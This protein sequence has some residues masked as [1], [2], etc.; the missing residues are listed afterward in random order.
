MTKSINYNR[1]TKVLIFIVAYNAEK[2]IEKV[3]TRIP[4]SLATDYIT[5]VLIIDDHSQDDTV[6]RCET[7][8]KNGLLKFET[9]VLVNPKNQGYGGNQKIGFHYAIEHDY[10][11]IVLLHGD[12]QY[13][14][15]CLPTLLQTISEKKA[16]AVFGSRMLKR[17]GALREGMP[18]YKY[19]GNKVLSFV[20][21]RILK[22]SLSE[23]HSGYRVYSVATLKQIPFHLNTDDFHFDTEIIIQLLFAG[24]RIK[25]CPIPTFYGGEICYVK[26]LKY[27]KDVV[28][29]TF[30]ARAQHLGVFYE[31]K[32]DC[33]PHR[34]ENSHYAS[35][36]NFDSPS[37]RAFEEIPPYSNILDI[38]CG[39]GLL[40]ERLASRGCTG[41]GVDKFPPQE[42]GNRFAFYTCDINTE[43][44]PVNVADYDYILMLDILE[45]FLKPE[46][47]IEKMNYACRFSPKLKIIASTGNI[48]FFL[49]RLMLLAGQFNYGKRGILDLTHTR[50]FTFK[51]FRKLFE[52]A[53]FDVIWFKGIPA[54]FVLAF[55]DNSGSRFLMW[56]NQLLIWL[57]PSLFSYQIYLIAKPKR[58]LELLLKD[59]KTEG[60]RRV[61][62]TQGRAF[63][64]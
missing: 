26:G 55:G 34:S 46:E 49:I 8:I 36:L 25:E 57:C 24:H 27:A 52:Q 41:A 1:K 54:P 30:K 45:H 53:G 37:L 56:L 47:F 17:F 64:G 20:Q 9:H 48:A 16:D 32:F 42:T 7:A 38:G 5:E 62:E 61:N 58:S 60:Y 23:F 50:L 6:A 22:S 15:E 21:N 40:L 19:I 14:P 44:L 10:D 35:K 31:R 12:G 63:E 11:Y 18:I 43:D 3:L 4:A 33:G 2:S 28:I 59:A 51:T 13:A 39:P 29:T